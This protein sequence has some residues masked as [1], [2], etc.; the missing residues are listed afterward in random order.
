MWLGGVVTNIKITR[1]TVWPNAHLK[2][3]ATEPLHHTFLLIRCCTHK[4]LHS[5]ELLCTRV[6]RSY[7]RILPRITLSTMYLADVHGLGGVCVHI[8]HFGYHLK[9]YKAVL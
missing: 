1:V 7:I 2:L 8:N 6:L 3:S 4:Q 9:R 5:G